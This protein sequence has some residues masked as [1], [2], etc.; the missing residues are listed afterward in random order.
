VERLL[1]LL[2][3][4]C[5]EIPPEVLARLPIGQRDGKLLT[6][7]EWTFGPAFIGLATCPRCGDRLEFRFS[8]GEIRRGEGED[9][10][11]SLSFRAA[12]YEVDFRLPNSLDL[13]ALADCPDPALARPI[14]LDRCLVSVRQKGVEKSGDSLPEGVIQAV[15]DKM[16]QADPQ[17]HI[18]FAL[19][20]PSCSHPWE[21]TFDIGSFFWTEI[22]AWACRLLREVHTLALTYGWGESEILALSPWRRQIYLEMI[23]G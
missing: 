13:A 2:A 7:R 15:V 20:C 11:E 21:A 4:A 22:H 18:Q 14:L 6:L 12:G 19:S 3:A 23:G 10:P 16:A 17:A 5:P 8:A 9:R 1:S